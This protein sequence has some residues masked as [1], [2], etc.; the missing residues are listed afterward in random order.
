MAQRGTPTSRDASQ[1]HPY[2]R[3]TPYHQLLRTTWYAG[4]QPVVGLVV[5]AIVYVVGRALVFLAV[6]AVIALWQPHGFHADFTHDID[7]GR[8]R[9]ATLLAS[10]FAIASLILVAWAL[11][12]FVHGLQPRWLASVRPRIRWRFLGVCAGLALAAMVV[13]V[14]LEGYLP[15]SGGGGGDHLQPMTWTL[16][17]SLLIVLLTT[18]FQAAGEEYFFRGYLLQ[19]FGSAARSDVMK[20]VAIVLTAGL[21]A[22]AHAAQNLPLFLDRFSF[23][24]VVAWL[25][26]RT[27]GLEAG[28]ALHTLNNYASFGVAIALGQ[29]SQSA[30]P[31]Q[32]DW[33][34]LVGR[35]IQLAVYAALVL[36]AAGGMRPQTFTSAPADAY[37]E[38]A[39]GDW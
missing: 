4:W 21:F 36:W 30:H 38:R 6:A 23:G 34:S 22:W 14:L 7:E 29:L 15:H 26:I 10:D 24:V 17:Q 25:V 27:G 9:P 1:Q 8:T 31:T 2:A 5:A 19:V 33:W 28:I 18:P 35:L 3:P 13:Q 39:R 37:P 20:W 11:V 32:S 12:R 16:V